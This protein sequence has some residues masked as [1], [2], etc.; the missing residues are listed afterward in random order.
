MESAKPDA[1][2]TGCAAVLEDPFLQKTAFAG[3]N[4]IAAAAILCESF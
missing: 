2:F 1:W 4:R 3:Q